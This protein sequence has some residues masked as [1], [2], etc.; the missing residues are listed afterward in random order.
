MKRATETPAVINAIADLAGTQLARPETYVK[1]GPDVIETLEHVQRILVADDSIEAREKLQL[2][3]SFQEMADGLRRAVAI[4][5]R[6][7]KMMEVLHVSDGL[8]AVT[9]A[10]FL[11]A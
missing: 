11:R 3:T 9:S 1:P 5:S 8:E 2:V 6:D 4:Q 10:N 7:K